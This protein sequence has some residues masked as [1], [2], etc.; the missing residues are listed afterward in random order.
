[1]QGDT[2]GD[3][4]LSKSEVPERLAERMFDQADKNT[5][6]FLDRE[7]LLGFF[8]TRRGP[9]GEGR[10]G[11]GGPGGGLGAGGGAGGPPGAEGRGP[12]MDFEGH[13]S[14]AGR[15]LRRIQRSSFDASSMEGDLEAIQNIQSGLIGAKAQISTIEMSDSARAKYGDDKATYAKEFRTHLVKA[16][17]EALHLEAAILEGNGDAARASVKNL[18]ALQEAAHAIFEK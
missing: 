17:A 10:G 15:G 13:M 9:G 1:M 5:D 16:A 2:D 14:Q 4:K 12:A 3:G 8:S 18:A 7:E 11:A 6:G